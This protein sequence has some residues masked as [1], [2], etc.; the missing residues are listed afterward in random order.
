MTNERYWIAINGPTCVISTLPLCNPKVTPTPEQ[1]LGFTTWEDAKHAQHVCL[2]A[3]MDEVER[4]LE[5][6]RP[7]VKSGRVRVIQPEHPQ[8]PTTGKTVWTESADVHS[9]I[10]RPLSRRRPT[11]TSNAMG[12]IQ[13][14]FDGMA[15]EIAAA[16]T[17]S[18]RR[19]IVTP[20]M[21][22]V[23]PSDGITSSFIHFFYSVITVGFRVEQVLIREHLAERLEVIGRLFA[24]KP[25]LH[26]HF[27][28][29]ELEALLLAETWWSCAK[30]TELRE[31]VETKL[32]QQELI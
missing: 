16:T 7:D 27:P 5:S 30:V 32:K 25:R 8:P 12:K 9:V 15:A 24:H 14:S 13:M 4:F 19:I 31:E 3:E 22:S 10:Q 29:S 28:T 6:L 21:R 11:R 26:L 23:A 1:L 2:T 17:V 20:V 18:D